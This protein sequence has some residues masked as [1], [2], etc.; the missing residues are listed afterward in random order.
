MGVLIAPVE[1]PVG[2]LVERLE[3]PVVVLV[4]VIQPVDVET[5]AMSP[6]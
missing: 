5:R 3:G 2:A 6:S 1:G 4:V